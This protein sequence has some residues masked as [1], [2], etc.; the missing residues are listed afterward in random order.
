MTKIGGDRSTER[1]HEVGNSDVAGNAGGI[2]SVS[3]RQGRDL[4]QTPG[5]PFPPLKAPPPSTTAAWLFHLRHNG[6]RGCFGTEVVR[7]RAGKGP[8]KIVQAFDECGRGMLQSL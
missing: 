1:R 8:V 7:C 4:V 6:S 3:R 5:E 2:K